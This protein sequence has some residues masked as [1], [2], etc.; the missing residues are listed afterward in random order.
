MFTISQFAQAGGVG[1][2]TVRFYQRKTLLPVPARQGSTRHYSEDDLRRLKFIKKAQA[3][4]F[5]LDEIKELLHL[6]VSHDHSR[7]NEMA[8][9]RLIAL[10]IKIAELQQ[11]RDSLAK[12][13]LQCCHT[14]KGPCPILKA[15]DI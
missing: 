10:D 4:G 8:Q 6:D 5:T 3:A 2:E 1:V 12:L 13:S 7:A 14:N 9:A 15:F 11:A